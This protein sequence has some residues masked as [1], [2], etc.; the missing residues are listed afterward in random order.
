[1][2]DLFD[3]YNGL[4]DCYRE[5]IIAPFLG[6]LVSVFL[7]DQDRRTAHDQ[8]VAAGRREASLMGPPSTSAASVPVS[9][10]KCC[11]GIQGWAPAF[12]T[13]SQLQDCR[14]PSS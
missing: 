9:S 11:G 10:V 6:P 7:R 1:L 8:R 2:L 4:M 5:K 12:W 13:P 3:E 14:G